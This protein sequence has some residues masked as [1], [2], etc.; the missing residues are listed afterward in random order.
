MTAP[1]L[2]LIISFPGPVSDIS[3]REHLIR[4]VADLI[5]EV[6]EH[7]DSV[8]RLGQNVNWLRVSLAEMPDGDPMRYAWAASLGAE[9]V[10][11]RGQR[12]MLAKALRQLRARVAEMRAMRPR[13]VES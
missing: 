9:A 4:A 2:T 8:T 11:W 6:N 3:P 12:M 1:A 5:V 10:K 13:L 7:R